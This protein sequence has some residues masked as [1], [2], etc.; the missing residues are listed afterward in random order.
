MQYR[1]VLN[2]V[3]M[4]PKGFAYI[5]GLS[6][7]LW[8]SGNVKNNAGGQMRSLNL[9]KS[10]LIGKLCGIHCLYFGSNLTMLYNGVTDIRM[11]IWH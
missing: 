3:M 2:Q 7:A 9:Q 8:C 1:A 5:V 4:G 10:W 11:L 6:F